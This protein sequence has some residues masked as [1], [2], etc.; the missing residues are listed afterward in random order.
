[1]SK[2]QSEFKPFVPESGLS[3]RTR[4]EEANNL[5]LQDQHSRNK[6]TNDRV[7]LSLE[8]FDQFSFLDIDLKK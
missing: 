4:K 1:M 7:I 6:S 5:Q 8:N 2:D 3:P